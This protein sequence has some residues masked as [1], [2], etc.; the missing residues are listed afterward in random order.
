MVTFAKARILRLALFGV[1]GF[2]VQVWA[3][4]AD[5]NRCQNCGTCSNGNFI[6]GLCVVE[7]VQSYCE[8]YGPGAYCSCQDEDWSCNCD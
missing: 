3:G 1:L 6:C 4:M 2:T 5:P 7:A 8:D